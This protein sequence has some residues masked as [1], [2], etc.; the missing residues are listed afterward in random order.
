MTYCEQ[1]PQRIFSRDFTQTSQVKEFDGLLTLL[2]ATILLHVSTTHIFVI[3]DH[4]ISN[5]LRHQYT[6][7]LYYRNVL[8]R[9]GCVR[10]DPGSSIQRHT[11]GIL[12]SFVLC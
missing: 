4:A 3:L 7:L 12:M 2:I 10:V 8:Q 6:V 11:V 9:I 1:F 5:K